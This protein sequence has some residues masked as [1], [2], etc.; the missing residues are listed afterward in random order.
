MALEKKLNFIGIKT[1]FS[2]CQVAV[3]ND[4]QQDILHQND[5]QQETDIILQNDERTQTDNSDTEYDSDS[6]DNGEGSESEYDSEKADE[7]EAWDLGIS[8][9]PKE[10]LF[11]VG[12][13]S[14]FGRAVRINN[15]YV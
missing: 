3:S 8:S 2:F 6:S 9:L 1:I 13:R 15:K 10:T 11:L 4:G 14:R 7:D 5:D 12:G